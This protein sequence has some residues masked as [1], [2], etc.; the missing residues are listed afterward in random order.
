MTEAVF[1]CAGSNFCGAGASGCR[2]IT[3]RSRRLDSGFAALRGMLT[4]GLVCPSIFRLL[5][6]G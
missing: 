1:R 4:G 3:F 2:I 5:I 6:L